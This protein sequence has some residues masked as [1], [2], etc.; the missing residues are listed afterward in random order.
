[1]SGRGVFEGE[2]YHGSVSSLM[3]DGGGLQGGGGRGDR[4]RWRRGALAFRRQRV[5]GLC[6]RRQ[7]FLRLALMHACM[8]AWVLWPRHVHDEAE[9]C[10]HLGI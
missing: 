1:M 8:H 9:A 3:C 5:M 10:R 6:F 4:R 2:A 7:R